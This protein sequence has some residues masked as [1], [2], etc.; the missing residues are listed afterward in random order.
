MD[1]HPT[2]DDRNAKTFLEW[3]DYWGPENVDDFDSH[4]KP[5]P[6]QFRAA[7]PAGPAKRR[8]RRR[9]LKRNP[10]PGPDDGPAVA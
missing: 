4:E 3:L 9:W 6:P 8:Q 1:H 7:W 10:A 5:M 2:G